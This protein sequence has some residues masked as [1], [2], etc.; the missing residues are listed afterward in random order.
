MPSPQPP[1]CPSLR[2]S[3]ASGRAGLWAAIGR[4]VGRGGARLIRKAVDLARR[5]LGE[6]F[7]TGRNSAEAL[8]KAQPRERE[9]FRYSFDLLGEAALTARDAQRCQRAYQDAIEAIGRAPPSQVAQRGCRCRRCV[10]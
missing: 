4:L 8:R 3:H 6:Q 10:R 7:A 1:A 9:G 5:M 2:R